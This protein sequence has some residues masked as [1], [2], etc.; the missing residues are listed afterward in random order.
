MKTYDNDPREAASWIPG[1]VVITR[2]ETI[3]SGLRAEETLIRQ[4]LDQVRHNRR[5]RIGL[6]ARLKVITGS[7]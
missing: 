4:T 2:P 7:A 3:Q 5:H 6:I 1:S